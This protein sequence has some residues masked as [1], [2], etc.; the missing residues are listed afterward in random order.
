MAM[1][2]GNS[3]VSEISR[4]L[5]NYHKTLC[6]LTGSPSVKAISYSQLRRFFG[7]VSMIN[8]EEVQ[9]NY[10]KWNIYSSTIKEWISLDGKELRGT[11]DKASGQKRAVNIVHGISQNSKKITPSAFYD[12]D[13]ESEIKT[14]QGLLE[15]PTLAS[16]CITFDALHTQFDTLKKIEHQNGTYIAQVKNNQPKLLVAL[17]SHESSTK[18]YMS[19]TT[20]NKGH[21]RLEK[22]TYSFFNISNLRLDERWSVC[23]I[24]SMIK[25]DRIRT[26]LKT[27]TVSV[28]SSYYITNRP[29]IR[30]DPLVYANAIRGHW[31]I[32]ISNYIRDVLFGEDKIK[33]SNYDQAK[34]MAI[35]LSTVVNL[36]RESKPKNIK[37]QRELFLSNIKKMVPL[38]RH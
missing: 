9:V 19:L 29:L 26:I 30:I 36:V 5:V 10:F 31:A 32:E 1:I 13:K 23:G 14:V 35:L 2:A 8:Y 6:N 27:K 22:R 3:A 33:C 20:E 17:K 37:A 28:E 11:I 24:Q 21:G 7:M 4:F 34:G 12:G 15:D 25:V 38:F 18:E 16:S